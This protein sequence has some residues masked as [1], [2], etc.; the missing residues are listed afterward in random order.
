[1]T[2]EMRYR[3]ADRAV[4]TVVAVGT[5]AVLAALVVTPAA[6]QRSVWIVDDLVRGV[7]QPMIF[8]TRTRAPALSAGPAL[9]APQPVAGNLPYVVLGCRFSDKL[10]HTPVERANEFIGNSYPGMDHFWRETSYNALTLSG[11]SFAGW[12]NL[13]KPEA[14]YSPGGNV[15]PLLL[16]GDCMNA[17]DAAVNFLGYSGVIL[18]VNGAVLVNGQ[19]AALATQEPLAI[20]VDGQTRDY[21]AVLLSEA[22]ITIQYFWA[23][24]M[25]H[26]LGMIHTAAPGNTYLLSS[27]WD[28]MSSGG[29]QDAQLGTRVGGHVS[30]LH[31]YIMGWIP[32]SRVQT[33]PSGSA[34][35]FELERAAEPGPGGRLIGVLPLGGS[36]GE[37]YSIESKRQAGYDRVAAG[38][39]PAEGVIIHRVSPNIDP[40]ARLINDD[41]G[42][43]TT[44][45]G[46]YL[47][48]GEQWQDVA[49]NITVRNL[50]ATS[51]GYSVRVCYN[52]GGT[53]IGDVNQDGAVNIVDAQL[54]ARYAVGLTVTN[55]GGV[56]AAGDVNLD[57]A[58]NITDA[59][60]IAR[61]AVGLPTPGS[62]AGQ[63][64]GGC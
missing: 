30:N 9:V 47:Q 13:P 16:A 62:S 20:P 64:G 50:S 33:V 29:Y 27:G 56:Q 4:R 35:T 42:T 19:A 43:S 39:L 57:A 60:L 31:K 2:F 5:V 25:G 45:P 11:S 36:A 51:T 55:P 23:H 22:A 18:L 37:F 61:F 41:G 54:T 34:V 48:P 38:A 59:Q 15:Q 53:L 14:D 32:G 63:G 12:F 8:D 26:S 58:V 40:I 46:T 3:H 10:A 7:H 52:A 17:A 28:L 21:R 49:R 44:S 6:A 24:E 1:M